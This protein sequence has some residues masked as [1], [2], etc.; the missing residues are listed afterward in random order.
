[1]FFSY[2]L[3]PDIE[4]SQILSTFPQI[5][6]SFLIVNCTFGPNFI[7]KKRLSAFIDLGRAGHGGKWGFGCPPKI[8]HNIVLFPCIRQQ[9]HPLHLPFPHTKH[10]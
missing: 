3:Q 9:N 6:R 7:N 8:G 1:M 10:V 5:F 4:I 2:V